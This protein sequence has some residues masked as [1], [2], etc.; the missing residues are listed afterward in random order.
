MEAIRKDLFILEDFG[1]MTEELDENTPMYNL[2][3]LF[4]YSKKVGKAPA[5]LTDDERERFRTN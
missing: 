3:D 2:H 1:V 5:E 4:E